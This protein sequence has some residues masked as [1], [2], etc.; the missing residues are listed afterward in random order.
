MS[1][2]RIF[3]KLQNIITSDDLRP[4]MTNAIIEDG[5]IVATNAHIMLFSKIDGIAAQDCINGLDELNGV[6]LG[7][8]AI[9]YL[10]KANLRLV[11]FESN[12]LIAHCGKSEK[13]VFYY[14][15]IKNESG[16]YDMFDEITGENEHFNQKF[17]NWRGDI[18]T[19]YTQ[20]EGA[21]FIGFDPKL[22]ANI[23]EGFIGDFQGVKIQTSL[24]NR[25]ILVR[26]GFSKNEDH[27]KGQF[28]ILMPQ[29]FNEIEY[30]SNPLL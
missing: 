16:D 14:S 24:T 12:R 20:G 9:K 30:K 27:I 4:V 17:P 2:S 29:M 8:Q 11:N 15:G 26:P 18:P 6:M 1:N 28:A 23:T 25:A 7:C 5:Y 10:G 19:Q 22:L 13:R 21:D 3:P